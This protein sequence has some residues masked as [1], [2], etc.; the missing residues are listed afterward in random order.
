MPGSPFSEAF[1]SLRTSI[2]LTL[3]HTWPRTILITSALGSAGKST[4]AYNLAVA[5]AQQGSRILLIDADLRNP[6]L[7]HLFSTPLSPGLSEACA[8]PKADEVAGIK[9]HPELP[10]FSFLSAGERPQFPSEVFASPGFSSLLDRLSKS[11]DYV[12]IDSP[13]ILAVTD[14]SIIATKVNSVIAVV[15]SRNTTRLAV[16]AVAQAL[17]RAH[18]PLQGFVLND[19]D[20]PALDGF[21][22][23][24]Y[25][26]GKG[27]QLAANA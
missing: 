15:R 18:V 23:Y 13:P 17:E 16:S 22:E 8:Q 9:Q 24:S 14:A 25:S 21:Y 3:S 1:R 4:V 6:D 19:V 27:G 26:R 20:K 7:H 2:N 5:Y 10:L 11:F 12:L